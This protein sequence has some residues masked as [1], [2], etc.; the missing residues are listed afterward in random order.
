MIY[1]RS[2][3]ALYVD[4]TSN[5]FWMP[6]I[7]NLKLLLSLELKIELV[8]KKKYCSGSGPFKG[9]VSN[10][11]K[12]AELCRNNEMF[13]VG[14]N[15]AGQDECNGGCC[16]PDGSCKCYCQTQTNNHACTQ[17]SDAGY[18][19]Y[20]AKQGENFTLD[21]VLLSL[22]SSVRPPVCKNC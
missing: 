2:C 4:V 21:G 11:L 6:L 20:S 17:V 1:I 18:N 22:Q 16:K 13:I 12:C 10:A 9:Y 14:T 3:N 8:A 7:F 19:L 5:S 15:R